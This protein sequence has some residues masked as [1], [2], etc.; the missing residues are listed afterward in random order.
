MHPVEDVDLTGTSVEQYS[1][2][3]LIAA[4]SQGRVYRGRD[5]R[6]KRDVAIKVVRPGRM[7]AETARRNLRTE[8]RMLSRLDHPHVAGIYD[9]VSQGGRDFIVME[10][11]AGA[12]LREVLAGGP[13]PAS[14]VLRLGSQIA[15]GVA[16]A[17]AAHIVHRDIK[18]S[19]LKITSSGELKILDFGVAKLLPPAGRQDNASETPTGDVLVVGTVPYMAP[20]QLRGEQTDERTDIFSIGTVLYEMATGG[21]PFPQRS[22]AA[23]I[24]A[25]LHDDP[26]RASDVNPHV[27]L[28]LQ[29]VI[30]KAMQK[31]LAARYRSAADLAFALETLLVST[32]VWRPANVH[33]ALGQSLAL[34]A[35]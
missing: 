3:A 16:A 8:A 14:E 9:F 5:E 11:V 18:P 29:R 15:H 24:E 13:L 1:I 4:G 6:L 27:P 20:E 21:P 34:A 35:L 26:A 2:V 32:E 25:I 23:L 30:S 28:P 10:F 33:P 12:T 7:S 19:N 22:V 31:A 17:H